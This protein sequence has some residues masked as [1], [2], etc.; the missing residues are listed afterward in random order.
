MHIS[1]KTVATQ[2]DFVLYKEISLCF[3]I[4]PLLYLSSELLHKDAQM[5]PMKATTYS[6]RIKTFIVKVIV[7]ITN[8]T[9]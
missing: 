5:F 7:C 3:T 8:P 4:L 9:C 1:D 6:V 2:T